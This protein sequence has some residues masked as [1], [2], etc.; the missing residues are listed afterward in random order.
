MDERQDIEVE[1]K[2]AA[3]ETNGAEK[4]A[5]PR[6]NDLS[7]RLE[8]VRREL[9]ET[10][11]RIRTDVGK[12][13]L[14]EVRDRTRAWMKEHPGAVALMAAGAGMMIGGALTR[15][16]TPKPAPFPARA[17]RRA[18]RLVGRAGKAARETGA[19][20]VH[21]AVDAGHRLVDQ[22]TREAEKLPP[23]ARKLG[24]ALTHRMEAPA[25]N[26][27]RK[28]ES[29]AREGM[30]EIVASLRSRKKRRSGVSGSLAHAF[31]A[32]AAAAFIKKMSDRLRRPA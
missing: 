17:R 25:E 8:S 4:E 26:F 1:M 5:E 19:H 10:L 13:D 30:E 6:V 29:S 28:A 2:E 11:E 27:V 15:A 16:L 21:E 32:V 3:P 24:E 20:F 31:R 23:R 22:V 9:R 7:A 18:K 12:P 14:R